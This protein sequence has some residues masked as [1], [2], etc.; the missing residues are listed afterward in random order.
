VAKTRI[1]AWDTLIKARAI[2]NMSYAI[3]V[4]RVGEDDNGYEYTG[5]SQLVDYL[6]YLI[7]PTE[8][9]GILITTLDKSKCLKFVKA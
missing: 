6:E 2:E 3:G 9:E 1:N 5:H 8:E 4:N 7:E